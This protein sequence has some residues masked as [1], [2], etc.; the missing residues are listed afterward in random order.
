MI[1]GELPDSWVKGERVSPA[2]PLTS[3]N[4]GSRSGR[5]P[6][7]RQFRWTASTI[8]QDSRGETCD[9]SRSSLRQSAYKRPSGHCPIRFRNGFLRRTLSLVSLRDDYSHDNDCQQRRT[10]EYGHH[11]FVFPKRL[12]HSRFFSQERILS[13]SLTESRALIS[14]RLVSN[15]C[16]R[17]AISLSHSSTVGSSSIQFAVM[18]TA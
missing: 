16:E 15:Q 9:T 6:K 18:P 13:A 14:Y 10:H 8:H 7:T 12:A 3:P 2:Y 5:Q 1:T 4:R 11:V 17:R